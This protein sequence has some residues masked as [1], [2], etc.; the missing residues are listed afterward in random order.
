MLLLLI[1]R[2]RRSHALTNFARPV[3]FVRRCATARASTRSA[4]A[5]I[6]HAK[7]PPAPS[8]FVVGSQKPDVN[9]SLT[10]VSLASELDSLCQ[11]N[12]EPLGACHSLAACSFGLLR[13][14]RLLDFW[15]HAS[16]ALRAICHDKSKRRQIVTNGKLNLLLALSAL[17]QGGD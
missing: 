12:I 13:R 17:L 4:L 5:V 8:S 3:A 16:R 11:Q 10:L 6:G 1:K 7:R 9:F 14:W 15:R 2:R